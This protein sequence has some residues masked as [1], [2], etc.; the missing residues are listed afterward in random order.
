MFGEQKEAAGWG[1]GGLRSMRS[2]WATVF[3]EPR[4]FS[5]KMESYVEKQSLFQFS[6]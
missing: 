1:L 2:Q 6:L 4:H 5:C 3:F